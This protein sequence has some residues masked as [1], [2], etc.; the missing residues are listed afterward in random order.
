MRGIALP[1]CRGIQRLPGGPGRPDPFPS[2]DV[3]SVTE[4]AH[5]DENLTTTSA[6]AGTVEEPSPA[7]VYAVARYI[8]QH[9]DH[10]ISTSKLQRLL[11]LAQGWNLAILGEPLFAADFEAWASGPVNRE[12]YELLEGEYTVTLQIFDSRVLQ[13]AA[14]QTAATATTD[15]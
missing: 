10:G 13:L 15:A 9:F 2:K 12:I 6:A 11:Y 14:S 4:S 3:I 8:V 1:L 7:S 5:N